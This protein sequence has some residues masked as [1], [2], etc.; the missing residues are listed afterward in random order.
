MNFILYIPDEL[1][2][3]SVGCYGHPLARTPN[4]DRLAK[5]GTRFA[6]CHV[7]HTVCSPSRCSFVT[8]WYPHV[9]GHRTLWH[10]LRP[11]EP[12]LFKYLKEAGY[13]VYWG[14][15]NDVLAPQSFTDSVTDFHLGDRSRHARP[16]PQ[17][18]VV[19]P[20]SFDDPRYYS[21]LYEPFTESVEQLGDFRNV[22]AAIELL[23]S[24]PREPFVICLPLSLPHPPYCAPPS[25]QTLFDPAHV[26]PLRP[27]NLPNKPDFHALIR[28]YRRLDH[29][30]DC[31]MRQINA[32]YLGMIGV[33]D[34]LLGRLL[35][36]LDETGLGDETAVFCFSD[37][38]D[39]AGDYGL[40]EKWPSALDDT[41]THVP[42]I[43][44]VP[45][46]RSGHVVEE[47][48][49]LFD[50]MATVLELAEVPARHTHFA[51]S[52][53]PQLQGEMGDPDRA[54]FA[55]GG[56]DLDEPH[57]FEG[58]P[59]VGPLSS[60]D[61]G[62]YYPKGLLQQEHP[63]SVGR[64]VMVRTAAHK[65]VY[66]Q[67]GQCELYD[68]ETDPHEVDNLYGTQAV[69]LIQRAL[70]HRLLDWYLRTSDVVPW[71]AN[72]RGLPLPT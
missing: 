40:V 13:S 63:E 25:W 29:L 11:D 22:D 61:R 48:I 46:M 33:T 65:L 50:L 7:Q 66:R 55:E 30:D 18:P 45:R 64:A 60:D 69:M 70:E 59:G 37:H 16:G 53:V 9:R 28:Q 42:F 24:R 2:A 23:R 72:P 41:L 17:A 67:F 49:E 12:N 19:P 32:I 5:E 10:L 68:L 6:Q 3:E 38:G 26:P 21:F 15:K 35:D 1:R 43:V 52:L 62:I 36:A 47:P 34:L 31:V 8:G 54:A 20:W 39:W 4:M 44:R 71:D 57:C 51:R 14:G 58:R 56:Y 27:A